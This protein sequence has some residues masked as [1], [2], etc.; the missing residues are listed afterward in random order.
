MKNLLFAT[1]ALGLSIL[2]LSTNAQNL[3]LVQSPSN[4]AGTY[5]FTDSY[6]ADGWGADLSTTSVS[7][8]GA[9]AYDV[10]GDSI[11]CEDVANVSEVTGKIAF[12]YRGSCNFSLKAYHAQAAGAIAC[13]IVN[14]VAGNLINML[15]GDS[16]TAVTIPVVFISD[17]DGALL[18]DSITNGSGVDIFIGNPNGQFPNNIGA[19]RGDFGMANSQA[20]PSPLV[21][22]TGYEVPVGA[23]MFNFGTA[24]SM[25]ATVNAVIDRDGTVVYDETST[26]A[27]ILPGDSLFVS[28][29]TYSETAYPEGL[30]T[31]TYTMDADSTDD[32]P[33][34]NVNVAQFWIN[35]EGKY[36]KSRYNPTTGPV[37]SSGLRPA[38]GTE[39]EWCVAL[40]SPNAGTMMV[41][42]ITFNTLT[43][44]LD[45]TGQAVQL[46]LYEWNDPFDGLSTPTFDDLVELTD[47]E[48]YDYVSDAQGEFVTHSFES[49][50]ELVDDQKYLGCA[51]IIT[52]NMFLG[53]DAGLDY[54]VTYDSY[55]TEL[56]FPLNDIDG[57]TWYSGGFGTDN[58]PALILNMQLANGIADDIESLKVTPYPNPTTDMIN[59]PLGVTVNGNVTVTVYDIEG[60]MVLA[61]D[62]CQNNSSNIRMDVSQLSSGIHTFGLQFEDGSTTSFRVVIVR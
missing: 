18:A 16:A 9:I 39:F 1:A 60:R 24:N 30:Y 13:V 43:N 56:F 45:L 54:N 44:D 33:S 23:W 17:A 51:T 28:L 36:S 34:D 52:D 57:G 59:I 41:T 38:N 29:P 20:I 48:I 10:A 40:Q 46:S 5:N 11:C 6:T 32:L 19:Y 62:L 8:E 35:G 31:I 50:I 12:L 25:N 53:V 55:P 58:A 27:T 61:E 21:E 14:N 3:F 47:N 2:G 15:A 42:G 22:N 4:L 26:G 37:G 7:G 49:P